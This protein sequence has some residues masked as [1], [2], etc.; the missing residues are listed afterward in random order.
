L[1]REFI[2]FSLLNS[3]SS[4]SSVSF[5]YTGPSSRLMINPYEFS[6]SWSCASFWNNER[7]RTCKHFWHTLYTGGWKEP[8]SEPWRQAPW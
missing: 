5:W 4:P 2:I 3:V 1:H 7:R 8:D 6:R